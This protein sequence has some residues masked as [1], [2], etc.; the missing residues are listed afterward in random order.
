MFSKSISFLLVFFIISPVLLGQQVDNDFIA[1][2]WKVEEVI[3]PENK[4]NDKREK[5]LFDEL[6]KTVLHFKG[7]GHFL[8]IYDGEEQEV[9]RNI[10]QL[11]N[12][13]WNTIEGKNAILLEKGAPLVI[14]PVEI[15]ENIII[16]F[17]RPIKFQVSKIEDEQVNFLPKPIITPENVVAEQKIDSVFKEVTVEK[18]SLEDSVVTEYPVLEGCEEKKGSSCLNKVI[19][20]S[21]SDSLDL[22]KYSA[23]ADLKRI[24]VF[25]FFAIDSDGVIKNI[26]AKSPDETLTYDLKLIINNIKV[27]IPAKNTDGEP[28]LSTYAIP[29]TLMVQ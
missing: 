18:R 26:K 25:V 17:F 21:I 22:K 11:E 28:M 14:M 13:R 9:I 8:F 15:G 1:G 23:L 16:E 2:K 19:S 12:S 10:K 4:F 29:V 6:A 3:V 20:R 27:I 24:K 5:K 7:D